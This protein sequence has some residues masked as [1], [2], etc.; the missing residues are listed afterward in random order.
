VIVT[1]FKTGDRVTVR[2]GTTSIGGLKADPKEVRTVQTV[3]DDGR[4]TLYPRDD[5]PG[6]VFES[7]DLVPYVEAAAALDP[8]KVKA[9]DTVTLVSPASVNRGTV[10][11]PAKIEG[12]AREVLPDGRIAVHGV[13]GFFFPST[14]TAHQPAPEPEPEWKPGTVA[15]IEVGGDNTYR[16]IRT[17][18][19]RWEAENDWTFDDDDVE[20]VRPLVVLDPES[21]TDR[22][23]NIIREV[24]GN[25]DLG[26]GALA[27]AIL[28]RLGLNR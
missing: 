27:E 4:V 2:E 21:D 26:A 6:N 10:K 11:V 9:G 7:E 18:V 16:A 20:S 3:W 17:E 5:T 13:Q 1:E 15:D 14:L 23:W 19:G 28:E 8:S 24:D 12:V 25:H 22:L